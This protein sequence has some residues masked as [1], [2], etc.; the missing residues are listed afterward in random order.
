MWKPYR[1][2]RRFMLSIEYD[3]Y[4]QSKSSEKIIRK[5]RALLKVNLFLFRV[6]RWIGGK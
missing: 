5:Y 1:W 2:V 6:E 3:Y 4:L